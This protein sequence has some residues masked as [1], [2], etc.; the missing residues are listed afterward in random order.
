MVFYQSSCLKEMNNMVVEEISKYRQIFMV[1]NVFYLS[2]KHSLKQVLQLLHLKVCES[3]LFNR[4]LNNCF[5]SELNLISYKYIL[6][7]MCRNMNL[8][9]KIK[10]KNVGYFFPIAVADT[11]IIFIFNFEAS[12]SYKT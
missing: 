11:K 1:N 12:L 10:V 4:R 2:K 8:V 7:L 5:L 9:L 6:S 3:F